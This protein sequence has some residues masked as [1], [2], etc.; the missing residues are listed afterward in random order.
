M[1]CFSLDF[2]ALHTKNCFLFIFMFVW[3]RRLKK[4]DKENHKNHFK[5]RLAMQVYDG[6]SYMHFLALSLKSIKN[7]PVKSFGCQNFHI[8][9]CRKLCLYPQCLHQISS[10]KDIG[11]RTHNPQICK[12][13]IFHNLLADFGDRPFVYQRLIRKN[14]QQVEL[15]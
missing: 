7:L 11:N 2:L 6:T 13:G 3:E 8:A 14:G 1:F 9:F 15:W 4:Y 5:N 12:L 10:L